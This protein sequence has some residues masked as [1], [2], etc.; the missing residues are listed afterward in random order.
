MYLYGVCD[1]KDGDFSIYRVSISTDFTIFFIN[2][3]VVV[4]S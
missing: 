1:G 3:V 2:I 4:S